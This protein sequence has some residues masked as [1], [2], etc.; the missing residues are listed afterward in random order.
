MQ[1]DEGTLTEVADLTGGEFFKAEDTDALTDVLLD[2]PD[3]IVL[4]R[5]DV[6]ITAWFALA[7]ALLVLTALGLAQ[8]WQRAVAVPLSPASPARP[9]H[10]PA[11][12]SPDRADPPDGTV[13]RAAAPPAGSGAV[14][15]ER[16][17]PRDDTVWKR[18]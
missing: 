18:G 6:E 12:A 2:L 14:P 9:P 15:P 17:G 5:E 10:P 13:W 16:T 3:S 11:T 8:W 1:A 7:G 4:Q